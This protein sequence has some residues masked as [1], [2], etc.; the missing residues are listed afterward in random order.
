ME[1]AHK[2]K[3]IIEAVMKGGI[4]YSYTQLMTNT[5]IVQFADVLENFTTINYIKIGNRYLNPK[6]IE[7]VLFREHKSFFSR[8]MLR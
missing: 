2:T 7:S 6:E 3:Y 1:T 5:E 4:T 8:L